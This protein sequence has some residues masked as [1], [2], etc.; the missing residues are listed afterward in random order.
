MHAHPLNFYSMNCT[1]QELECCSDVSILQDW[2]YRDCTINSTAKTVFDLQLKS[3]QRLAVL[4]LLDVHRRRLLQQNIYRLHKT[5]SLA[6]IMIIHDSFL[7]SDLDS[8]ISR[9]CLE[10]C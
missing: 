5:H 7:L 8:S 1:S 9:L 2:A 6:D 10:L 3:N 4:I